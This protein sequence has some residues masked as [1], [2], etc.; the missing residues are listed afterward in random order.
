M[1]EGFKSNMKALL[2]K[3]VISAGDGFKKIACVLGM[4]QRPV[5]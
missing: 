1:N 5:Y 2:G 3:R 4:S